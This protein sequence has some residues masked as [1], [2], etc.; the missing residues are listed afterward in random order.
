[1]LRKLVLPVLAMLVVPAV[2]SAQFEAGDFDMTLSGS[3]SAP[4]NA[5]GAA[6]GA[7]V[8]LGYF[9][10]KE[11]EA[12]VRQQV[13]YLQLDQNVPGV[14]RTTWGGSTQGAIDYHFDFGAFQPF[15]GVFGGYEYPG[16]AMGYWGVGPEAGLK[17]FVNGTTYVYGVLG[18]D[19]T[20]N[21]PTNS[22]FTG[23]LGV[24]FKF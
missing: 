1:M 21:K 9:L 3:F 22:Y 14:D 11:F 24:G 6:I 19:Y 5:Q 10:T 15:V 16:S 8:G 12:S 7:K 20:T 2:A 13:T 23:E 17:Y 4:K 18:Y